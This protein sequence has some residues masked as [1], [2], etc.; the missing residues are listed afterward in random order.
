MVKKFAVIVAAGSGTRMGKPTPK[1]YLLLNDKPVL[2]HTLNT[3]LNAY[4]EMQII[5]VVNEEYISTAEIIA[6]SAFDAS[7]IKI[8][9]GGDTRFHSVK[10]GLAHVDDDSIVFVHDAVRCL[11]T[12]KL[13]ARCYEEALANGNAIPAIKAVD[14]MRVETHHG[15]VIIDR[16]KVHIIQTPQTFKSSILKAAFN[17]PYDEA[18]TDEATVAE[19]MGEKINLI[20]GETNNIKITQPIDLVIAEKILGVS[21]L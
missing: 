20:E 9:T 1:Q 7:R 4:S 6:Q 18:F 14:S 2:L 10:N 5:L 3:F 19:M 17:Q 12:A 16:D 21:S 11:V 13:I 8:T 15:N